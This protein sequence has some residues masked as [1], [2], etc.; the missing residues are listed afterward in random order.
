MSRLCFASARRKIKTLNLARSNERRSR[1]HLISC[2]RHQRKHLRLARRPVE[3][4]ATLVQSLLISRNVTKFSVDTLTTNQHVPSWRE[5]MLKLQFCLTTVT[6]VAQQHDAAIF[7]EAAMNAHYFTSHVLAFWRPAHI[8]MGWWWLTANHAIDS[9]QTN[10]ERL[11][12]TP[13]GTL[14]VAMSPAASERWRHRA[15]R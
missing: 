14:A 10:N 5:H 6:L 2:W 3:L 4:D 11:F 1:A 13:A 7:A 12:L 9:C 15:S 8:A